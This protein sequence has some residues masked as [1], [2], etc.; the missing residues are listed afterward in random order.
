MIE[1]SLFV[2]CC[3]LI[4]WVAVDYSICW[5]INFIVALAVEFQSLESFESFKSLESFESF[6]SLE[7]FESLELFELLESF[8]FKNPFSKHSCYFRQGNPPLMPIRLFQYS[9]DIFL[10]YESNYS[11]RVLINNELVSGVFNRFYILSE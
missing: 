5:Y 7:S 11:A 3:S 9:I 8:E 4:W 10:R 6:K 1:S 2:L